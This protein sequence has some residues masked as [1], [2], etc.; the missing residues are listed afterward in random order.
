MRIATVLS[1]LLVM[2]GSASA[3]YGDSPLDSIARELRGIRDD[4]FY[5]NLMNQPTYE[6]PP[7]QTGG[8]YGYS[9]GVSSGYGSYADPIKVKPGKKVKQHRQPKIRVYT[10]YSNGPLWMW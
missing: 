4:N 8:Y 3:Q 6:L 1:V 7:V 2:V 10:Y 5:Y 9:R